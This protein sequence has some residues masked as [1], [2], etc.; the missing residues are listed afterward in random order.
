VLVSVG[1]LVLLSVTIGDITHFVAGASYMSA[2]P[3][4]P[5]V[6][7]GFVLLGVANIIVVGI[8]LRERTY[9]V[10]VAMI[11]G[12]IVKI[13]LSV[14]VIPVMGVLGVALAT[15][16]AFGV[17]VLYFLI[18]LRRLFPVAYALARILKIVLA[19]LVTY[20]FLALIPMSGLDAVAVKVAGTLLFLG[21]LWILRF[22]SSD[23]KQ[24]VS[25]VLRKLVRR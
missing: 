24:R 3:L 10:S 11:C 21:I 19:G 13:V 20:L 23:E 8:Y 15:L 22:P 18:V 4:V 6:A 2:S 9:H 12:A 16:V 5:F 14:L 25:D 1:I 17:V 7:M